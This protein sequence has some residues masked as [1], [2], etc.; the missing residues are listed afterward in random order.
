MS[1]SDVRLQVFVGATKAWELPIDP[2]GLSLEI[3]FLSKRG[4][5][6]AHDYWQ[7]NDDGSYYV[8][9]WDMKDFDLVLGQLLLV[10]DEASILKILGNLRFIVGK[11]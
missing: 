3:D 6:L 5:Y 11:Y 4:L 1:G 8:D 10:G 7:K 9:L 2:D